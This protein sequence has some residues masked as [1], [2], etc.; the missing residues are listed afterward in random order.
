MNYDWPCNNRELGNPIERA[1]NYVWEADI[2][3]D[4]LP[5]QVRHNSVSASEKKD[6]FYDERQDTLYDAVMDAE[7]NALLKALEKTGGN[8][9]AAARL[10][11]MSRSSFY[12]RLAKYGIK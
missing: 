1:A 4:N 5:A 10:L 2:S 8:K 12:D 3:L 11:K 9:S 7:R 6:T